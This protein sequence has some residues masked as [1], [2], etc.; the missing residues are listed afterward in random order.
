MILND[1][2]FS[3]ATF[4]DLL[5]NYMNFDD[6]EKVSGGLLYTR[7]LSRDSLAAQLMSTQMLPQRVESKYKEKGAKPSQRG[8]K[9]SAVPESL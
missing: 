1:S 3:N 4:S 8:T 5:N 7:Y 2:N 9:L 6:G